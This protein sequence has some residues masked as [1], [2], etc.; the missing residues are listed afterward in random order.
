MQPTKGVLTGKIFQSHIE[1]TVHVIDMIAL[2][3]HNSSPLSFP[4]LAR[5]FLPQEFPT[6]LCLNFALLF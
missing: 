1:Y 4:S 2:V 6:V 5:F 3:E